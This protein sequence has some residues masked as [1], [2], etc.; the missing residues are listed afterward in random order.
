MMM[1]SSFPAWVVWM[2]VVPMSIA[3]NLATP[4]LVV[5]SQ[6]IEIP[7]PAPFEFG[8]TS[9]GE[10]Y[11]CLGQTWAGYHIVM[12]RDGK[13]GI[14]FLPFRDWW[15]HLTAEP[16]TY[17]MQ[18]PDN[19]LVTKVPARLC[20][21][22]VILKKGTPYPA[23]AT[24]NDEYNVAFVFKGFAA[25][26]TVH[27]AQ[28]LPSD[29]KQA[30]NEKEK[31]V[32][33]SA[34]QAAKESAGLRT[35]L[36]EVTKEN[37]QLKQ[38]LQAA[39]AASRKLQ[40]EVEKERQAAIKK[41]EPEKIVEQP[42]STA[43][44]PAPVVLQ[45]EAPPPTVQPTNKPPPQ[46]RTPQILKHA[47]IGATVLVSST[48]A[49]EEGEDT[50]AA[51]VDGNLRTRWSSEYG[52]PH[53]VT[54]DLGKPQKLAKLRLHW[55]TASATA[56]RVSFSEDGNKWNP[57]YDFDMKTPGKPQPRVDDVD[58]RNIAARHIRVDL[59]RRVNPDWGF[60]LYEIE[61]VAAP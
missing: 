13:V 48:H 50:A 34:T 10:T 26:V 52:E 55:E 45:P 56:Y 19:T 43:P 54:L 14:G 44:Q 51:L 7:Q 15:G 3:E 27:R 40:A 12:S 4:G 30:E 6:D 16:S 20:P 22:S 11:D 5:P 60:S 18:L 29:V 39:Q 35:Q 42:A 23:T 49:G 36:D 59:L 31:E 46:A 32:E 28:L 9:P 24:S 47:A 21:G 58:M 17:A 2:V 38:D 41:P 1:K 53:D 8:W 33:A 37:A 61:A 57:I 25:T